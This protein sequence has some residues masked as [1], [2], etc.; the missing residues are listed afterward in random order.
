[1]T[2]LIK[3][4]P[5]KSPDFNN[6]KSYLDDSIKNNHFTNYGP[7]VKKLEQRLHDILEIDN[8]RSVIIVD[9]GTSAIHAI[10]STLNR[11]EQ[12]IHWHTQAF[13]FPAS[14]QGP[15]S[16]VSICDIDSDGGLDLNEIDNGSTNVSNGLIVTNLFGYLLDINKY[17]DWER[18]TNG[19]LIFDNAATPYSFYNGKNCLNYGLASII[20]L[21]HTKPLGFGEGGAIIIKKT[22]ETLVRQC[23]NFGFDE[24]RKWHSYGSNYKMSDLA[25]AGIISYLDNFTN[26]ISKHKELYLN[27]K[28]MISDMPCKLLSNY[29]S[30]TPFVAC[31][32]VIFE[33]NV[34]N[35]NILK[36]INDIF[37]NVELKKYYQPLVSKP[38]SN[39]LYE[40]SLCFPCHKDLTDN[41]LKKYKLILQYICDN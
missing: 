21:H 40:N 33:E 39:K 29:S 36:H 25:A 32:F 7:C 41:D 13:T 24:N 37:P 23:L 8:D 31:F 28:N 26:I 11:L 22:H 5:N 4:V 30:S 15:L 35:S 27:F 16:N 2:N 1:M 20:S 12:N 17:L 38:N 19:Y 9:N 3:W 14:A 10:I 6:I 18:N 34:L